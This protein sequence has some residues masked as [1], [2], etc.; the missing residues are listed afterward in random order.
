VGLLEGGG[1]RST[2]GK[3]GVEEDSGFSSSIKRSEHSILR[4]AA[5]AYGVVS[6]GVFNSVIES[7]SIHVSSIVESD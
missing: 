6:S 7:T 5:T 2:S 1:R 3:W 4:A